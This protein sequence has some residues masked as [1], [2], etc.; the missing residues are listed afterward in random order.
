[1]ERRTRENYPFQYIARRSGAETAAVEFAKKIR[2]LITSIEFNQQTHPEPT[3]TIVPTEIVVPSKQ[4][5]SDTTVKEVRE[6]EQTVTTTVTLNAQGLHITHQEQAVVRN[7]KITSL[8]NN[9]EKD[10]EIFK[11]LGIENHLE[12]KP[13]KKKN[14]NKNGQ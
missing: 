11:L 3:R 6:S 14:R 13:K 12:R 1:M 7:T 8:T 9:P 5:A 10:Q 4:E 2:K